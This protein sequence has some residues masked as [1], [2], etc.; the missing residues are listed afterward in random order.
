MEIELYGKYTCSFPM[1]HITLYIDEMITPC[2]R[3]A[4]SSN[5]RRQIGNDPLKHVICK[6]NTRK[7]KCKNIEQMY[8]HTE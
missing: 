8:Q 5:M 4:A 6:H 1:S 7:Q 3:Q 2:M